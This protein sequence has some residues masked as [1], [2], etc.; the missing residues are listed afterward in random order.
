MTD[1][2]THSGLTSEAPPRWPD[3]PGQRGTT[4][5]PRRWPDRRAGAATVRAVARPPESAVAAVPMVGPVFHHID[6]QQHRP[7]RDWALFALLV[8]YPVWRVL[9]VV[10]VIV[11]LLAIP[12]ALELYRRRRLRFPAGASL[13]I[14]LII[15]G[16]LSV[17]MINATP[18]GAV[19]PDP[20]LNR[21]LAWGLRIADYIA[22]GIILLYVGNLTERELPTSRV[23]K[24]LGAL[25]VTCTLG[26]VAGMLFGGVDVLT[27]VGHLLP[28]SL[29]SN[30][31]ISNLVTLNLA[32]NQ[33][34][35]GATAP[36]PEFPLTYTNTWGECMVLL[37][38]WFVLAVIRG[39]RTLGWRATGIAVLV[40]AIVPTVY[41]L[42]RGMWI[43]LGVLLVLLLI[44][45]AQTGR[46]PQVAVVV[47]V[48]AVAAIIFLTTPL[49][50]VITDRINNPHSNDGRANIN[51][52]AV[53]AAK[54]SPLIGFGGQAG[55][56]G[57]R[58]SIA[59]GPTPNCPQCGNLT[60]GG[61]GQMWLL[62]ITEGF[63]GAGLYVLFFTRFAWRYRRDISPVGTAGL[64]M[65]PSALWF[66]TVYPATDLPLV[67]MFVG[68]GLWWRNSLEQRPSITDLA[69][70]PPGGLARRP[71]GAQPAG[72]GWRGPDRPPMRRP[73]V[74]QRPV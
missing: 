2:A 66:M 51:V 70:L 52:A 22:A 25:F 42:N 53:N 71:P 37:V 7:A 65:V 21:Y 74:E 15:I 41:S 35:I 9:G 67:I 14:L 58:R 73:G 44:R 10:L 20:S 72:L 36:R 33:D 48:G 23:I 47:G 26:G 59:I 38:P 32:Q 13:W 56:I 30:G 60:I 28:G 50:T 18:P 45:L 62:L 46:G 31:F 19:T 24:M 27:P 34:I 63:A 16:L 61:D 11:P 55:V 54:A 17:I 64:M 39:K 1:P 49:S 8:G 68:M 3:A 4:R 40:I 57:S 43:G 12:M 69:T 5:R 29:R 6:P